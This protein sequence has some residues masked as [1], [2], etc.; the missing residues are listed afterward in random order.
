MIGIFPDGVIPDRRR[1]LTRLYR[2]ALPS[3]QKIFSL[4]FCSQSETIGLVQYDISQRVS[5]A[6]LSGRCPKLK[7][8]IVRGVAAVRGPCLTPKMW[9][10]EKRYHQM[11]YRLIYARRR[12]R[13]DSEEN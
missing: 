12:I 13:C 6:L 5:T 7:E 3:K 9:N 2:I 10:R 11:M 8:V 1:I 4:T